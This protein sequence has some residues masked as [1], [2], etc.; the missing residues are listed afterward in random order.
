[1]ITPPISH[2]HVPTKY[3]DYYNPLRGYPEAIG[4]SLDAIA[5]GLGS[6]VTGRV[7]FREGSYGSGSSSRIAPIGIAYRNASDDVLHKAV[8]DAVLCTHTHA[9][10]VDGAFVQAKAIATLVKTD[11]AQFH[12]HAFLESLRSVAR[13]EAIRN[14]I[15]K[16]LNQVKKY[17]GTPGDT[18][19]ELTTGNDVIGNGHAAVDAIG[20]SLLI[21][22]RF[23]KT[24]EDALINAVSLGGDTDTITSLTGALLGALH[25]AKWIPKRWFD[26]IE[27]GKHGRDFIIELAK[28]LA[29]LDCTTSEGKGEAILKQQDELVA[30]GTEFE[31]E[32]ERKQQVQDILAKIDVKLQRIASK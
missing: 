8:V 31:F 19:M 26:K 1:M 30:K 9:Q 20:S 25:G 21:F 13:T 23:W 17:E 16:A 3:S 27:N 14:T 18:S 32:H 22:S 4:R 28:K 24:P 11:P 5:S 6:E 2:E 10:S 7:A 12:A 29:T 15:Q